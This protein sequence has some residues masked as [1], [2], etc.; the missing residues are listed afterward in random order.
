MRF[1][2]ENPAW[3]AEVDELE[4]YEPSEIEVTGMLMD[5]RLDRTTAGE[6]QGLADAA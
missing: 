2:S 1:S 5:R 4:G 6:P 3:R